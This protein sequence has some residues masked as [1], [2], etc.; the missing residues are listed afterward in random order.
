[1]SRARPERLIAIKAGDPIAKPQAEDKPLLTL[2]ETA[3]ALHI[4]VDAVKSLIAD[5]TLYAIR[6]GSSG[7]YQ[8][9]PV[10]EIDKFRSGSYAYQRPPR[11]VPG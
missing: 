10:A 6:L 1:M 8:R 11:A 5:G 4:G 2:E 9:V 3:R 7:R